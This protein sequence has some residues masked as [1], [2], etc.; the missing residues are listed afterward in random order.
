MAMEHNEFVLQQLNLHQFIRVRFIWTLGFRRCREGHGL[1]LSEEGP[2]ASMTSSWLSSVRRILRL[3]K[4][5][6]CVD[7]GLYDEIPARV[8]GR[9]WKQHTWL[10]EPLEEGLKLA[11]T[12]R[13]LVAG[14]MYSDMQYGWRVPEN[15][16]VYGQGGVSGYMWRVCRWS[17]DTP[18]RPRWM[19]TTWWWILQALEFSPL[20]CCYWWQACGNQ[21]VSSAWL[22]IL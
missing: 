4:K 13:H 5:F 14:T 16:V 1:T 10:R 19:E 2:L 20:C 7:P 6:L 12:L 9:I 3:F 8:R 11:V 18:L 21:I 22:V 15:T 17:D